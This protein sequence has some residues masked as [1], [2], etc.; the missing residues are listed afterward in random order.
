MFGLVNL[1]SFAS[2]L[3]L[4]VACHQVLQAEGLLDALAGVIETEDLFEVGHHEEQ[5]LVRLL[6]HVGLDGDAIVHLVCKR[7]NRIIDNDD[8]LEL[9][10]CNHT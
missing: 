2:Y 5:L 8:V 3:V 4:A 7:N 9:S 10:I 1:I 6:A